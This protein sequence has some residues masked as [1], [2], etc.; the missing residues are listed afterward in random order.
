MVA[1]PLHSASPSRYTRSLGKS[2]HFL[3]TFCVNRE[4]EQ[5]HSNCKRII[6][7]DCIPLKVTP[8]AV[9]EDAALLRRLYRFS[10]GGLVKRVSSCDRGEFF[11]LRLVWDSLPPFG[12]V[13]AKPT[14]RAIGEV[15][16]ST[17]EVM[18]MANGSSIP[19]GA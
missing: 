10:R 18:S 8:C 2:R 7:G 11:S 4:V 15:V 14:E 9:S 3:P 6:S 1:S 16:H 5:L 17:G 13:T 19:V 12:E